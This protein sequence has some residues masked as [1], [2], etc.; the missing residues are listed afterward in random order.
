MLLGKGFFATWML[1]GCYLGFSVNVSG[2]VLIFAI[3]L[4]FILWETAEGWC[5]TWER[6]YATVMLLGCYL[7][8]SVN[9]SGKMFIF[10]TLLLFSMF[11]KRR[12]GGML[13]GKGLMLLGCYLDATWAF[14]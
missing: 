11:G 12:R 7:G 4:F 5:A 10:I 13:L 9:L 3:L 14:L 2:K 6:S 8:F 1:L